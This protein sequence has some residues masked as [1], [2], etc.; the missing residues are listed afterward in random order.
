M[1]NY[2]EIKTV[3]GY[4][5]LDVASAL[6]KSIRRGDTKVAGYFAMELFASGMDKYCWKRLL[7]IGAEDVSDM[8]NTELTSLQQNF[9]FINEGAKRGQKKGRIFLTKAVYILCHAMKSRDTDHLQCIIYD[10]KFDI[11]DEELEATIRAGR[12]E[13]E[14]IP[15]YAYDCHTKK[16]KMSGKTKEDFLIEEQEALHP[17]QLGLFDSTLQKCLEQRVFTKPKIKQ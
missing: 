13:E 7:T 8:V 12:K 14:A 17:V 4:A 15:D 2:K 16:G 6:Q 9:N 1:G 10:Y 5:L 11:T 3:R